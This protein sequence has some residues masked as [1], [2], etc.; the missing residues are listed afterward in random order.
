MI[1]SS[2]SRLTPITTTGNYVDVRITERMRI[3]SRLAS[4]LRAFHRA[5]H[6]CI[7]SSASHYDAVGAA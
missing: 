3:V 6:T 4:R 1:N 7:S 5:G 2:C